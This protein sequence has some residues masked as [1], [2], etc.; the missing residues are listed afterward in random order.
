MK[1]EIVVPSTEVRKFEADLI[2]LT[3]AKGE[4]G[5]MDGHA[6]FITKL[7][8]SLIKLKN[9]LEQSI[10]IYG[11]IAMVNSEKV[12]VLSQYAETLNKVD[13][14]LIQ[15]KLD[16]LR[17]DVKDEALKEHKKEYIVERISQYEYLLEYL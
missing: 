14:K 17:L 16:M 7:K 4:F 13:K 10:F 6:E 15:E 5:V 11:G 8:P 9:N 2:T 12:I 1:L 3:G